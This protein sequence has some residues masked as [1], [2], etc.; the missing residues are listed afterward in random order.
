VT[1]FEGVS[2]TVCGY[3]TLKGD[4]YLHIVPTTDEDDFM[5]IPLEDVIN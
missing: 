4:V 2:G 3:Y 1:T 5:D